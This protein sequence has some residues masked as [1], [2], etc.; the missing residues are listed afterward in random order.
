MQR[1]KIAIPDDAPP[2]M[3]ASTA[4]QA[5][6]ERAEVGYYDSLPSSDAELVERVGDAQGAISIRASAKFPRAVLAACSKLRIVSV[7]GTG[8]DH[9]DLAAAARLGITV[10]NTPGV[11]AVAMAEHALALMLAV[12]RRIPLIDA[13]TRQGSWPRGLITQLHGKTLGII[14][15]GA[16]GRQTARIARGIGMRVVA[17][18]MHPSSEL[19]QE[20]GLELMDLD[21]LYEISDVVSLHLRQS[22]ESTG[23]LDDRA[24]RRM[25]PSAI[26]INT[27]R[28]PIADEQALIAALEEK[29]I[30]G[31][32]LDVF[33][34]E[35]LPKDHPLTR[36]PN[37]VMTPH[38]GGAAPEVLE[39]GLRLSVDNLFAYFE[40]K[41]VNGVASPRDRDTR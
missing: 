37:V 32:G 39:A 14:G 36:L 12:A 13:Q 35:P 31:A 19:A 20:L 17:W 4:Y 7:W 23:L 26:F 10:T 28:G 38:S 1:F 15:L 5:L 22:P 25:K 29:R 6:L 33:D 11:S 9:V 3:G 41:P 27:A 8:T 2:V 30:A 40:G 24:F 34:V 16:I 21:E 18:T